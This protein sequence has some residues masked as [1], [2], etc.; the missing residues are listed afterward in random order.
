MF[1]LDHNNIFSNIRF[2]RFISCALFA[3]PFS[4]FGA[5]LDFSGNT[6]PVLEFDAENSSGLDRVYVLSSVSGTKISYRPMHGESIKWSKYGTLGGGYA[7]IANCHF[8]NGVYVLDSTEGDIGY[9]IEDGNYRW[10]FWIVDYSDKR[11]N[12]SNI[13]F[14]INQDCGNTTINVECS[15]DPIYY[16]GINGRRFQLSREINVV[17]NT[18]EWNN[19]NKNYLQVVKNDV[20]PS[21]SNSVNIMP[22]S[23]CSTSFLIQ[24]DRF[25]KA[26]NEIQEM[27]SSVLAPHSVAAETEAIQS[28]DGDDASNRIPTTS[29]GELGGSAP[30]ELSFKAYTTDGVVHNEWQ[31]SKDPE[32]SSIDYRFNE[33][34]VDFTFT[35]EGTFYVRYIGSNSDGSCETTGETYTI[36]I[37]SS[38]LKCPNAFSPNDDGVNDVWKVSY[39]SILE[40]KCWIFDR[41]GREV[42][43]FDNPSGGWDGKYNGKTARPGVYYY[44]IQ[45]KGADGKNYKKSGDIN[46][47]RYKQYSGS[48][49]Q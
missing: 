6:K 21:I 12:I 3:L 31:I 10:C 15:A 29:Q 40:F 24:G 37:G 20:L 28:Q 14:P 22:P 23:Y 35:E 43:Y 1:I 42:Y 17:Y 19:D 16:T 9:I 18:L 46:I 34:D 26:W 8:E 36:S 30:A 7:E 25:L 32:F 2:G 4:A 39:R 48:S 49:M 11:F 13:S 47:L 38:E 44:V 5:L 33:Q 41:N 45:A 27:E